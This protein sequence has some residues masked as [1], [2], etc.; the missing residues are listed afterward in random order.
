MIGGNNPDFFLLNPNGIVFGPNAQI[1]IGGSF[2]GTTAERVRFADGTE[3]AANSAVVGPLLTMSVP[4]GLQMGAASRGIQINDTGY[5]LLAPFPL[6][7]NSSSSLR[8]SSGKTFA[9][10]GSDIVLTGGLVSAPA[11][12][13]ELGSVQEGIVSINPSDLSLNYKDVFAFGNIH[14][15]AQSLVDASQLNP[16]VPPYASGGRG[17]SIQ[18]QGQR[19]SAQDGS[20]M[21][22]QNFGGQPSG[23]VLVRTTEAIALSDREVSGQ[24]GSGFSIL[25]PLA[26]VLVG[27]ST[28]Q[29]GS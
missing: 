4:T 8:V 18:V 6:T 28:F 27:V 14:L 24:I 25:M 7:V 19:L 26:V 17:G 29:L 10:L 20:I 9:L 3:F 22:I 21:L 23:S 5:T 15:S 16:T 1:D 11:G 12:R 2:I 13:I